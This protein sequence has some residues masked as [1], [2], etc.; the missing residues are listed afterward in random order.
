MIL[1]IWQGDYELGAKT[2]RPSYTK[3][4]RLGHWEVKHYPFQFSPSFLE[5][6]L[7]LATLGSS[8]I[9]Q[10]RVTQAEARKTT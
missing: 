6:W 1:Q 8:L 4:L 3:L 9:P 5:S 7:T 10:N 2:I